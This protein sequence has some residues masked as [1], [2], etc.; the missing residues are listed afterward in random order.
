MLIELSTKKKFAE[1]QNG[2]GVLLEIEFTVLEGVEHYPYGSTTVTES[3]FEFDCF[4]YVWNGIEIHSEE[5]MEKLFEEEFP[6]LDLDEEIGLMMA[7]KY[8]NFK[9][10]EDAKP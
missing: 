3:F 6:D 2:E 4:K 1:A 10:S 5:E 7:K 9:E 8:D